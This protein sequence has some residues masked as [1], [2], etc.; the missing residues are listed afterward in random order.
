MTHVYCNTA[1]WQKIGPP[2][3]KKHSWLTNHV[4]IRNMQVNK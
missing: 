2:C 4:S 1:G 3:L